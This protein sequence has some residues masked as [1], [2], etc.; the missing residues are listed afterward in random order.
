MSRLS[1][2]I[3][4]LA[5]MVVTAPPAHG[6]IKFGEPET[7]AAGAGAT[8]PSEPDNS[9]NL[10]PPVPL[11]GEKGEKGDVGPQGPVGRS[12][13]EM[14]PVFTAWLAKSENLYYKRWSHSG[15]QQEQKKRRN[16]LYS[17]W[18]KQFEQSIGKV[19]ARLDSVETMASGA[20]SLSTFASDRVTQA[21]RLGSENAA[22]INRLNS[23]V[24]SLKNGTPLVPMLQSHVVQSEMIPS[25]VVSPGTI[26]VVVAFIFGVALVAASRDR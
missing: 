26:I 24:E 12:C 5:V 16:T 6:Q 15:S 4:M 21:L 19:K 10:A 23:E 11:K 17:S 1:L 22:G 2:I 13:P 18:K 25:G 8:P 14:G 3:A 20:A 7:P 9:V